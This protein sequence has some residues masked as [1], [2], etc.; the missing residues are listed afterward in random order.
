ME[1]WICTNQEV[2]ACRDDRLAAKRQDFHL[3][4]AAFVMS[5]RN[6]GEAVECVW[7][8]ETKLGR[9]TDAGHLKPRDWLVLQAEEDC[10]WKTGEARGSCPELAN[11]KPW[12]R[13]QGRDKVSER[14]PPGRGQEDQVGT[15]A[16]S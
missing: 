13:R 3:G 1:G 8:G 14:E 15:P 6:P 7:A 12:E 2:G 10:W 5:L 11:V 4:H 16:G 9:W